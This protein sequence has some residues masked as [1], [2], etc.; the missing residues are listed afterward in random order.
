[1]DWNNRG[2]SSKKAVLKKTN[3]IAK[4]RLSDIDNLVINIKEDSVRYYVTY[5]DKRALKDS[6][7]RGGNIY[8]TISKTTCKVTDIKAFK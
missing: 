1:M 3:K 8:I 5:T 4:R 7:F 2:C 6:M